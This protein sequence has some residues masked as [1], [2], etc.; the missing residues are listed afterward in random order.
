MITF[1]CWYF[2]ISITYTAILYL[3]LT[4]DKVFCLLL[5]HGKDTH[6]NAYLNLR[7]AFLYLPITLFILN[8]LV[9]PL[10]FVSKILSVTL[11]VIE[12]S[13]VKLVGGQEEKYRLK[14]SY[15]LKR[16]YNINS[17]GDD[18]K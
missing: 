10:N 2:G 15:R 1:L 3:T 5:E 7:S 12:K 16:K 11:Q 4:S 18:N 13:F 9:F 8:V 14:A 17:G 6:F